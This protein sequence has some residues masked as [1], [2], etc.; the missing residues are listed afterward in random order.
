MM[1]SLAGTELLIA[2][3][4]AGKLEEFAGFLAP[5]GNRFQSLAEMGLPEPDETESSFAGNALLKAR[6]ASR[7]SG[8]ITLADDSGLIVDDLGGAPG[9]FT[10][11][12]AETGKGRDFG[13]AMHRTNALLD[14]VGSAQRRAHFVC[15][16]AVVSPAYGEAKF[17]GRISGHLVWPMR[18]AQ[19]HGYDPIFQPDGEAMTLAEMG[20]ARKNAISHRSRAFA[21]LVRECFT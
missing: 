21:A 11:D 15:V 5:Y 1:R 20:A 6:R 4:N 8:L 19:G 2:T 7:L 9:I 16:I 3:G 17:E 12:W 14:A 10:A 18:G 13:L